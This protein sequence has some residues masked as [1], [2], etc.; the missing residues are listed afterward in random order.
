MT[1]VVIG[2]SSVAAV[3]HEAHVR[4]MAQSISFF[5]FIFPF[6]LYGLLN[7]AQ[8]YNE[9]KEKLID[10]RRTLYL[11]DESPYL[12]DKMKVM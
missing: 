1:N 2:V 3:A 5:I 4:T 10:F 11:A 8:I 9:V 12:P 6:R 7:L